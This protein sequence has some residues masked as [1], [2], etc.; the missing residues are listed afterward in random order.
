MKANN[1]GLNNQLLELN[2]TNHEWAQFGVVNPKFVQGLEFSRDF[3]YNLL[4]DNH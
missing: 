2:F 4:P 3:I 1:Q